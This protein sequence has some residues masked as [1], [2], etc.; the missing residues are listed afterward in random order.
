MELALSLGSN[1]GDR[2]HNLSTARSAI[3][4]LPGV[5][6]VAS[7]PVYDTEP[8]DVP[9]A[10][11][12]QT[13]L[14]AVIIIESG[15]SLDEIALQLRELEHR[16]GRRRSADRNAPRVIDIDIIAAGIE[17]LSRPDLVVPHPRW[18]E[19]RFVVQPLADIRPDRVLPG[20]RRSVREVL[21]ALPERPAATRCPKQWAEV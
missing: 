15:S 14:N 17:H 2:L 16:L 10:Y 6:L 7:S 21:A 4:G 19:R 1:L 13:F 8:V 18:K 20:E 3:A 12:E 11:R 9:D 5:R